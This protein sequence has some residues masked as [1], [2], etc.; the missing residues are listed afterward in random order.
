M[1]FKSILYYLY[2]LLYVLQL[3][4]NIHLYSLCFM[5]YAFLFGLSRRRLID[6]VAKQRLVIDQ[7]AKQR[8]GID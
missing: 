8:L 4:S 1:S 3:R 7:V 6:Q 5:L 2:S